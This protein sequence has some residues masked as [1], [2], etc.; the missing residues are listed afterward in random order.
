[1]LRQVLPGQDVNYTTSGGEAGFTFPGSIAQLDP[2]DTTVGSNG[3]RF[4]PIGSGGGFSRLAA[5][6]QFANLIHY[7]NNDTFWSFDSDGLDLSCTSQLNVTVA[8]S[9]GNPWVSS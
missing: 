9:W 3:T 5:I 6:S 2:G 7:P 4:L 8:T 1:M